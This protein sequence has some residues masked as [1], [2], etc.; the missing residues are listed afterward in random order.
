MSSTHDRSSLSAAIEPADDDIELNQLTDT[1]INI[2][3]RIDV[4]PDGGYGWVVCGCVFFINAHTF[5]VNSAWGV[6]LAHF[7][8]RSLFEDATHLRYALIGGLS[9]SQALL[10]STVAAKINAKLGIRFSLLLGTLLVSA[11]MLAAS[12][13]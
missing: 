1:Q 5:G 10:V 13:L 3:E 7:L 12:S 8:S 9:I 2:T 6:F 4:R 11:S